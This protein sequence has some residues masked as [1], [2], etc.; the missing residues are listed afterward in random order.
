[1]PSVGEQVGANKQLDAELNENV[2]NGKQTA[3]DVYQQYDAKKRRVDR[4][5]NVQEEK[6][7]KKPNMKLDQ[8]K[9]QEDGVGMNTAVKTTRESKNK[10]HGDVERPSNVLITM[11]SEQKPIYSNV[12]LVL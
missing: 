4:E 8:T 5:K 9:P 12:R 11:K 6:K 10:Q 3:E 7:G 1:M 2:D